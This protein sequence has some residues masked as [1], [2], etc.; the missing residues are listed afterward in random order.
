MLNPEKYI[1]QFGV[2][3]DELDCINL[4]HMLYASILN[5]FMITIDNIEYQHFREF[6]ER[7]FDLVENM[8]ELEV[9]L[10]E[11]IFVYLNKVNNYLVDIIL[12]L[13]CLPRINNIRSKQLYDAKYKNNIKKYNFKIVKLIKS[14][15][16]KIFCLE[17]L[18]KTNYVPIHCIDY[19]SFY[20]EEITFEISFCGSN[21]KDY[22]GFNVNSG[23][24]KNESFLQFNM[25]KTPEIPI[26]ISINMEYFF[27]LGLGLFKHEMKQFSTILKLFINDK[28]IV[29]HMLQQKENTIYKTQLINICK[30]S[31]KLFGKEFMILKEISDIL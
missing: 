21:G 9:D 3:D 14:E 31:N 19:I 10:I 28:D 4:S 12:M 1:T 30:K 16:I 26:D 23:K 7:T 11:K 6:H 25:D 29:N 20:L 24:E 15:P 18:S 5:K 8:R 13:W 2:L 17:S 22:I 27:E